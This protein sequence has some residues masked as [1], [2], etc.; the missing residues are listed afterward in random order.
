MQ[1]LEGAPK[2]Q[3]A[4]R[5]VRRVAADHDG[6]LD[7]GLYLFPGDNAPC[8]RRDTCEPG[9]RF[10][11]FSASD[12]YAAIDDVLAG[13]DTCRSLTP[14]AATLHEVR[15][16]PALADDRF[17]TSVVLVTDGKERCDGDAV[18]AVAARYQRHG[19]RTFVVGFGGSA[20][21]VELGAMVDAGRT[22]LS[23]SPR[24][25][26]AYALRVRSPHTCSTHVLHARAPR[27][28]SVLVSVV[29][30]AAGPMHVAVGVVVPMLVPA[31][32]PVHM[33]LLLLGGDLGLDL[34]HVE[35]ARLGN[36]LL[37]R[38]GRQR[39]RLGEQ[40]HLLAE[41]R[42]GGDGPYA[43]RR[44]QPLLLLGVDLG[45]AYVRVRVARGLEDGDKRHARPAPRRPE[46]DDNDVVLL[47]EGLEVLCGGVRRGHGALRAIVA[48][49]ADG[50]DRASSNR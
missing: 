43:E 5:A 2:W 50:G 4:K 20:D 39:A 13:A 35:R 1:P 46:V 36:Q 26:S 32:R 11:D 19:A 15:A 41:D 12:P 34:A 17:A 48:G 16:D 40:Q 45:E 23:R 27:T 25:L 21:P 31:A 37:E 33:A 6:Q 10:L 22:A 49:V 9:R 44:R 29:E 24:T 38:G 3:I 7:F 14:I 8:S 30:A 18:G 42:D 28:P 47:D